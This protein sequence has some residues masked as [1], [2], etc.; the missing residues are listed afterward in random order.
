MPDNADSLLLRILLYMQYRPRVSLPT[1]AG[2]GYKLS[3]CADYNATI[4]GSITFRWGLSVINFINTNEQHMAVESVR[5][6][7]FVTEFVVKL[8]RRDLCQSSSQ[9]SL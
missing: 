4:C 7:S 1:T 3:T 9:R 8:R 6:I 2:T 5:E